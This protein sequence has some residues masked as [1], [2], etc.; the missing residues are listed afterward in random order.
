MKINTLKTIG[1][2]FLALAVVFSQTPVTAW[3]DNIVGNSGNNWE[4][5]DTGKVDHNSNTGD[6]YVVANTG[7]TIKFSFP[8]ASDG[9]NTV[10]GATPV[11]TI[12]ETATNINTAGTASTSIGN[13]TGT[14][15]ITGTTNINTGAAATTSIGAVGGY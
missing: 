4:Q 14:T 15:T 5:G 1:I 12:S 6:T 9:G 3:A 2:F 11:M 8:D 7:Q 13:A 10:T